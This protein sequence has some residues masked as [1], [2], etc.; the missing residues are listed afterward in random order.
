VNDEFEAIIVIRPSSIVAKVIDLP[1]A[2][3]AGE[4]QI[5]THTTAQAGKVNWKD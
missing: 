3:V 1:A 4:I 2:N 5:Y